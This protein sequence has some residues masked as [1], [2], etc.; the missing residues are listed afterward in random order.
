MKLN[1]E[2]LLDSGRRLDAKAAF[3]EFELVIDGCMAVNST[4][5]TAGSVF[6]YWCT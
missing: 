1:I 2:V 4:V 3:A 6:H 5:T